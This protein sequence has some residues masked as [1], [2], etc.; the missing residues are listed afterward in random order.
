MYPLARDV[1]SANRKE[2]QY[3]IRR[4]IDHEGSSGSFKS[5]PLDHLSMAFTG[6]TTANQ[7]RWANDDQSLRPLERR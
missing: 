6:E 2:V 4:P 5:V 7:G 1:A 3:A